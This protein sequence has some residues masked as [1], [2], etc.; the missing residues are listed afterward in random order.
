[1]TTHPPLDK[2]DRAVRGLAIG[3]VTH[4]RYDGAIVPG[5]C[6][7]YGA[8]TWQ[9]LGAEVKLVTAVGADFQCHAELEQGIEVCQTIGDYTTVFTNTYPEDGPRIQWVEKTA[10]RLE[11]GPW[12]RESFDVAFLAPVFGE[13][14]LDKWRSAVGAKVVGLGLQGF[15][16]KAGGAHPTDATV[17]EVV[18]NGFEI[19]P[20][21][22]EGI[23][24]VFFSEEDIAVFANEDLVRTLKRLVPLVVMTQGEKGS[25]VFHSQETFRIGVAPPSRVI[26]PTGAGDTFAAAFLFGMALELNPLDA[27]RLAAAAASIVVEGQGGECLDRVAEAWDRMQSVPIQL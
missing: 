9:S 4:D 14:E 17:R 3:Q 7:F 22:F 27:G 24:A 12:A 8:K 15:L 19:I 21:D 16:K 5:G 6:A 13:M 20:E 1:M 25:M 10:P 26:D 18:A 23:D 11:P 2:K